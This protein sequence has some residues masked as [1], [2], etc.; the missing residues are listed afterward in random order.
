MVAA[1]TRIPLERV[2][3]G[4]QG[5]ATMTAEQSHRL[6][7]AHRLL[8]P[9]I[10]RRRGLGYGQEELRRDVQHDRFDLVVIDHVGAMRPN[11]PDLLDGDEDVLHEAGFLEE[12]WGPEMS[13]ALRE[14]REAMYLDMLRLTRQTNVALLTLARIPG[15]ADHLHPPRITDLTEAD[16]MLY[17][18]AAQTVL[19]HRQPDRRHQVELDVIATD[20]T[21]RGST[22]LDLHERFPCLLDP[23][24]AEG[25]DAGR[26]TA[27][28]APA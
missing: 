6:A 4:G 3:A 26:A 23:K 28:D 14:R 19:L 5:A 22:T 27:D 13:E 2:R 17:S 12:D 21:D 9:I 15:P 25:N 24:P 1:H 20:W 7:D 16:D 11:G 18:L 10:V 8:A